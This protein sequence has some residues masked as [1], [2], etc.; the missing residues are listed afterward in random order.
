MPNEPPPTEPTVTLRLRNSQ[1]TAQTLYL[2]PWGD[3]YPMPP[4]AVFEVV[5]R[6]PEGDGLEVEIGD[7]GL[8]VWGWSGSVV[9]LSQDGVALGVPLEQCIPV[10]ATPLGT[11]VRGF[12]RVMLGS[13]DEPPRGE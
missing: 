7:G 5:A 12:L 2:E 9:S 13:E 6:G 10:P 1:P 11:G 3:A 8:I 4:G